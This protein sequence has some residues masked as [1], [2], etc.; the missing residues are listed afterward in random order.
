M[1]K[2][3]TA[4]EVAERRNMDEESKKRIRIYNDRKIIESLHKE[5][6]NLSK[7]ADGYIHCED[8][9]YGGVCFLSYRP[10]KYSE[11]FIGKDEIKIM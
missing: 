5:I 11:S 9:I 4:E 3:K 7:R 6:C 2:E 8:C 10:R 1:R